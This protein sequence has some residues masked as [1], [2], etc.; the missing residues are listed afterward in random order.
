MKKVAITG[1]IATGK[2][3]I[4]QKLMFMHYVVYSADAIAHDVLRNEGKQDVINS[5]G[6]FILNENDE[7]DRKV[8]GKIVF[9]DLEKLTRLNIIIHPYVQKR[10]KKIIEANSHLDIIFFEVPLLFESH[11]EDMF[12]A[13]INVYTDIDMQIKRIMM[14]D[15]KTADD[16]LRIIRS[17]MTT[18]ERNK[19][20]TYTINNSGTIEEM[21]EQLMIIVN[22]IL[23]KE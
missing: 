5:F 22:D 6:S 1:G 11:M 17:Q 15:D 20:A 7:I 23:S 18:F 8:L 9:N 21:Y 13:S 2:S 4:L 12:D 10:I 16:A 14:R 19:R 3:L